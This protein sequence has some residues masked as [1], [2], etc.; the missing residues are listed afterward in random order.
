MAFR[1]SIRAE[2]APFSIWLRCARPIPAMSANWVCDK[3]RFSLRPL[4]RR[5]RR[6]GN[7][8]AIHPSLPVLFVLLFGLP[9]TRRNGM[10]ISET[11]LIPKTISEQLEAYKG[12]MTLSELAEMLGVCHRTVKRWVQTAGLPAQKIR[13]TYW[14]DPTLA[15]RWWRDHSTTVAKPSAPRSPSRR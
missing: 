12:C 3:P 1:V 7:E 8:V 5:P 15:A 14:I 2:T 10:P 9:N 11:S 6:T 4:R 13:G